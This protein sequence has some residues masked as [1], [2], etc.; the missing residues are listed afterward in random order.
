VERFLGSI[1]REC[2]DRVIVLNERLL[3]RILQGYFGYY[4]EVR[5]RRS[6]AHDSPVPRPVQLPDRGKVIEMPLVGGLHH[7]YLRQAASAVVGNRL[8]HWQ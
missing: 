2:L 5:P 7:H 3:R 1:R 8:H 6:L 4:H